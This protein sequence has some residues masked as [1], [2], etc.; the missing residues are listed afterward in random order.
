MWGSERL[1]KLQTKKCKFTVSSDVFPLYLLGWGQTVL[2]GY[3]Q[4]CWECPRAK[5]KQIVGERTA[6]AELVFPR[7]GKMLSRLHGTIA[8][9]D[10]GHMRLLGGNRIVLFERNPILIKQDIFQR[11]QEAKRLSS[12]HC[13]ILWAGLQVIR[14]LLPPFFCK[15]ISPQHLLCL[16]CSLQLSFKVV[17]LSPTSVHTPCTRSHLFTQIQHYSLFL[18]IHHDKHFAGKCFQIS[19][20]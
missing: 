11:H 16:G 9:A 1:G 17:F 4:R 13:F 10:W 2:T 8:N 14:Y 15:S 5:R 6:T 19:P 3:L 18:Q 12:L 7:D 20:E